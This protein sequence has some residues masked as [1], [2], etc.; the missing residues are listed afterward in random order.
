MQ[1]VLDLIQKHPIP[2]PTADIT[3]AIDA[4]PAGADMSKV[5]GSAVGWGLI[6]TV[7][8]L[9]ENKG[10]DPNGRDRDTYFIELAVYQFETPKGI[11]VLDY[12]VGKVDPN[13]LERYNIDT[14][15]T[16]LLHLVAERPGIPVAIATTMLDRNS[17]ILNQRTLVVPGQMSG[18]TALHVAALRNNVP[19]VRLL[20]ERGANTQLTT[21]D[22]KTAYTLATDATIK[23]LLTVG[24]EPGSPPRAPPHPPSSNPGSAS[25]GRRRTRRKR[26][27][28][29]R[30][31]RITSSSR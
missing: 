7:K 2:A 27:S 11:D 26:S 6:D 28:R 23:G 9:V 25:G 18:L 12:L 16:A 10:V 17:G 20:K 8:Y 30:R 24:P 22:G 13:S 15:E 21:S 4:L 5:M 31:K 29:T 1:A 19:V 14:P 3:T